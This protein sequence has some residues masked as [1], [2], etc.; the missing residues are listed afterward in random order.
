MRL[1]SHVT[2]VGRLPQAGQ[3]TKC[4]V[5]V[6]QAT[7]RKPCL[8]PRLF[9]VT[10]HRT[11]QELHLRTDDFSVVCGRAKPSSF[12]LH[13]RFSRC[14]RECRECAAGSLHHAM[15]DEHATQHLLEC[16][17]VSAPIVIMQAAAADLDMMMTCATN[18]P[19][20]KSAVGV[21]SCFGSIAS[22][23]SSLTLVD[24]NH[25]TLVELPATGYCFTCRVLVCA[26][27]AASDAH[28]CVFNLERRGC[29]VR[30]SAVD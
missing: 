14:V 28:R 22:L 4:C 21:R 29:C 5:P 19:G 18:H 10:S 23:P 2:E 20:E 24:L 3:Q 8:V 9:G 25:Y 16:K 6:T 27:C 17:H 26:A 12:S 30:R 1:P 15:C 13:P 7:C 11:P